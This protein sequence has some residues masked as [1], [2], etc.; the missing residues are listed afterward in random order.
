MPDPKY[1]VDFSR[2]DEEYLEYCVLKFR[3]TM[4]LSKSRELLD[5][6]VATGEITEEQVNAFSRLPDY[7]K[8]ALSSVL[9]SAHKG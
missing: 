8:E 4:F 6:L 5:Y 1:N 9:A 3:L 2:L 7:P